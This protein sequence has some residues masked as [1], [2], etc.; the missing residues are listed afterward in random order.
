MHTASAVPGQAVANEQDAIVWPESATAM[1]QP[2]QPL[3]TRSRIELLTSGYPL[4]VRGTRA[5]GLAVHIPIATTP[6]VAFCFGRNGAMTLQVNAW[7]AIILYSLNLARRLGKHGAATD[8]P[9]C[10]V[11]PRKRSRIV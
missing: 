8:K 9:W 10:F 1:G 5:T 11:S 2:F 4:R 3:N 6:R 7:L